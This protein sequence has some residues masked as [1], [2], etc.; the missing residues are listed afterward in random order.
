MTTHSPICRLLFVTLAFLSGC[1][2]IG[3]RD[4]VLSVDSSPRGAVAVVDGERIG[5]TPAFADVHRS[6][7]HSVRLEDPATGKLL[8][9]QQKTCNVRWITSVIGN[10]VVAFISPPIA[11]AGLGVDLLTGAAFDC[12][13]AIKVN[14]VA[15]AAKLRPACHTYL[16][17]PPEHPDAAVSRQ[18]RMLWLQAARKTL[19]PCDR[20]VRE[21]DADDAF[22]YINLTNRDTSALAHLTRAHAN[23]LGQAVHADRLVIVH[24]DIA[25][26]PPRIKPEIVD[27]H[28]LERH[29]EKSIDVAPRTAE[30][31]DRSS[32]PSW[33]LYSVSL[34]PNAVMY[35]PSR[36]IRHLRPPVGE[37]IVN[38]RERTTLPQLLSFIGINTID[39]PLG[40]GEWDAT[41]RLY[42][43][44]D[45]GVWDLDM[46]MRSDAGLEHH[47]SVKT[48][49]FQGLFNLALSAYTPVGIFGAAVGAGPLP[50]WVFEERPKFQVKGSFGYEYSWTF[51][52][53]RNVFVWA[54]W[55]EHEIRGEL[56]T[57][58]FRAR[59]WAESTINVGYFTVA[60]E[61]W[62]KQKL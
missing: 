14:F 20:I 27:L 33:L 30:E 59:R 39:H 38:E 29:F 9:M 5:P 24:E 58:G 50:Y 54:A 10:S 18:V 45:A 21:A 35:G 55:E 13:G 57:K 56:E 22:G 61:R 46:T 17:A 60:P 3:G 15:D 16:V 2:T 31:L 42:P 53:S 4:E 41:L 36:M 7:H 12:R 6:R 25:G 19:A 34:I 32:R 1:A 43:S 62:V 47:T 28:S 11:L 51:F 26:K 48:V 44:L 8:A 23:V 37:T 40:F 52:S 49:Y